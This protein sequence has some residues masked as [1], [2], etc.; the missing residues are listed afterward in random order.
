MKKKIMLCMLVIY[1]GLCSTAFADR[2]YKDTNAGI[3]FIVPI[4]EKEDENGRIWAFLTKDKKNKNVNR[5][6]SQEISKYIEKFNN[7]KF[8]RISFILI[9]INNKDNKIEEEIYVNARKNNNGEHDICTN[10]N[11]KEFIKGSMMAGGLGVN[12]ALKSGYNANYD[13][14]GMNSWEG[15]IGKRKSWEI[16]LS[17]GSKYFT[18]SMAGRLGRTLEVF[19]YSNDL[20]GL[21][22]LKEKINSILGRAD[23]DATFENDYFE[24]ELEKI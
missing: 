8:N 22:I 5:I 19:G 15:P 12:E 24:I 17:N 13:F 9:S 23:F 18:E 10:R 6:S 21:K 1:M 2:V 4:S 3:D 7:D 16:T 20:T 11:I 14:C